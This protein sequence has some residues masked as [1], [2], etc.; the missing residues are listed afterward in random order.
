MLK[1]SLIA[2]M[3]VCC[4]VLLY[5]GNKKPTEAP[6][7]Q[8]SATTVG[9]LKIADGEVAGWAKSVA[10][11]DTFAAYPIDS[12]YCCQPGSNDGG[13]VPYDSGGCK[14][15]AY[16]KLTGPDQMQYASFAMDFVTIEKASAMFEKLKAVRVPNVAIPGF[17]TATAFATTG[18]YTVSV[19][20]HFNKFYF[21]I[22]LIGV[23]DTTVGLT[24]A[25][26]FLTI[27]KGKIQ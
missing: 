14:E 13:A 11:S 18:F 21:E 26:D 15:L 7:P 17:A 10:N 5:C 6:S 19:Y 20:A 12:L 1:K 9:Q 16:Q 2:S 3:G 27:F 22:V 4:A 24:A 25:K 8:P 23:T